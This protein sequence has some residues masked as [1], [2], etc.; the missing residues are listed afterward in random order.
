MFPLLPGSVSEKEFLIGE[1]E[2]IEQHPVVSKNRVSLK[3]KKV[4][5]QVLGLSHESFSEELVPMDDTEFIKET[6]Y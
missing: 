2:F 1:A 4:A 3:K 5:C 6:P